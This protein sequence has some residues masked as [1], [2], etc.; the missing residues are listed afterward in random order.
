LRSAGVVD[1]CVDTFDFAKCLHVVGKGGRLGRADFFQRFVIE[2]SLEMLEIVSAQR[3]LCGLNFGLPQGRFLPLLQDILAVAIHHQAGKR[4]G[5]AEDIS[6][7]ALGEAIQTLR[8][9]DV[10]IKIQVCLRTLQPEQW[11]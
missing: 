1:L 7:L 5:I 3:A 9:H 10:G 2:D 4:G 11:C 8:V 6:R